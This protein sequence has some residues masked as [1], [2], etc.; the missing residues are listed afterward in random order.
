MPDN[1]FDR[2]RHIESPSTDDFAASI[3]NKPSRASE[4]PVG[5]SSMADDVATHVSFAVE[6]EQRE[7]IVPPGVSLSRLPSSS[8]RARARSP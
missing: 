2:L 7:Y 3:A 6:R 5:V 4:K 8:S 1:A